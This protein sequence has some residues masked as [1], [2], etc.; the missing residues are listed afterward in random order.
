MAAIYTRVSVKDD[1]SNA[2]QREACEAFCKAK[3]WDVGPV[4]QE[5]GI[6]F[7]SVSEPIG[8]TYGK[9]F[10]AILGSL[11]ELECQM[12]ADRALLSAPR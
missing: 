5:R 10:L 8:G 12:K 2:R 7:E 3:G 9:V 4:F 1:T 6:Q 11:A